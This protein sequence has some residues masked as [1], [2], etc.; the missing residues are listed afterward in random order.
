[1]AKEFLKDRKQA[2][3]ESFF[4][5]ENEKLLERL[6][7]EKGQKAAKESLS[8]VSGITSDEVLDKLSALGIEA[9]TWAA[10]SIAPL[11][12]VAWAD[13]TMDEKERQAI[14]AGAETHGIAQDSSS[15]ALLEMW[16]C[17]PPK[18]DLLAA[19]HQYIHAACQALSFEGRLRLKTSILD[20]ARDVAESAGG[21]L[22]FRS[23]SPAEERVLGRLEQAFDD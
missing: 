22:G 13:G 6:R 16:L 1:M 9:D 5:R 12:E 14:L 23:V 15:F 10:V 11:V 18:P 21:F 20:G 7:A 3:E 4:A 17:D 8:E 19:W 2:L